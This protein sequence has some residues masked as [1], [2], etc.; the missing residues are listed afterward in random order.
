MNGRV[1]LMRRNVATL[2]PRL[3]LLHLR[4]IVSRL[5]HLRMLVI[6]YLFIYFA[7]PLQ[8]FG[9]FS[10]VLVFNFLLLDVTQPCEQLVQMQRV[11]QVKE[12]Q[13]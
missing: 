3:F 7:L 5:L 13:I 4:G 9:H 6:V 10:V 11:R 1:G 2:L 12:S 8:G